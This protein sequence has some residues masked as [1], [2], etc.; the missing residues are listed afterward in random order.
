[1]DQWPNSTTSRCAL[2]AADFHGNFNYGAYGNLSRSL[3]TITAIDEGAPVATS[4]LYARPFQQ[5]VSSSCQHHRYIDDLSPDSCIDFP[6]NASWKYQQHKDMKSLNDNFIPISNQTSPVHAS[7]ST[8]IP[9]P[10]QD[11]FP[12]S[13]LVPESPISTFEGADTTELVS[14]RPK[15]RPYSKLQ[16]LHLERDF[17][18]CMYPSKERRAWLSQFLNLTERQVKIWFQ[19]RRTK[20]KRTMEREE[21]DNEQMR[22]D[23]ANLALKFYVA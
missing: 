22:R 19:N 23:M 7:T 5:Q 13:S 12:T 1:M 15:R 2:D 3:S 11:T 20:M 8:I 4:C 16:L 10:E 14:R 21:R 18:R 6:T 9:S 17:Q